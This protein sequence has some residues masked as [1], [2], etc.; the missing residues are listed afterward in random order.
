MN[1][2]GTEQRS[3][4]LEILVFVSAAALILFSPA[5]P[6]GNLTI[7][8]P[9][10]APLG[11]ILVAIPKL[12]YFGAGMTGL[13]A[14]AIRMP[15]AVGLVVA[16]SLLLAFMTGNIWGEDRE[17]LYR[18]MFLLPLVWALISMIDRRAPNVLRKFDNIQAEQ[19]E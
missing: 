19:E 2:G 4:T 13:L 1:D 15:K 14:D 9:L 17:F 7:L 18:I 12:V 5:S 16:L 3:L 10:F 8:V 11:L 6:V